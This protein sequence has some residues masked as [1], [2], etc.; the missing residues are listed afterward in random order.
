M[1]I[2]DQADMAQKVSINH[3]LRIVLF[4]F[5]YKLKFKRGR[6]TILRDLAKNEANNVSVRFVRRT[7]CI[8]NQ[9]MIFFM[10][11]LCRR[12]ASG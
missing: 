5:V 3:R 9:L 11:K 2:S 7:V 10:L 12:L 8:E 4:Y 1:L 6:L